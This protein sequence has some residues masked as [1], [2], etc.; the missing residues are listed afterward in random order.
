MG[1]PN[2]SES[3]AHM[4]LEE[5]PGAELRYG[6]ELEK[7]AKL[8]LEGA[9]GQI[10]STVMPEKRRDI[11]PGSQNRE[12]LTTNVYG[13]KMNE[14]VVVYRYEI[15]M[16]AFV[17]KR[18]GSEASIDMHKKQHKDAFII[19]HRDRCREIFNGFLLV[20][21][22][23][24]SA[25]RCVYYDLDSILFSLDDVKL[26]GKATFTV[27][28]EHL[29]QECAHFARCEVEVSPVK[30]SAAMRLGDLS[31]LSLELSEVYRTLTQFLDIA[32][33]QSAMF[34][35]QNHVT[36]NAGLSF[37]LDPRV[38]GFRDEDGA[39]F[40][41]DAAYLSI[42][43]DKAVRYIEGPG[44]RDA[45]CSASII[46]Q[47][48]KTPFHEVGSLLTKAKALMPRLNNIR[49]DDRIK[50]E[51]I[52]KGLVVETTHG[53][54]TQKFVIH[55]I[56]RE[57]AR[58]K[59]IMVN[60][61]TI[62][63]EKYFQEK[64]NQTLTEPNVPL[65]ESRRS[66]TTISYFPM[67]LCNVADNQRVKTQQLSPKMTEL[68]IRKC[69]VPP[70]ILKEQN[71]KVANA[72]NLWNSKYLIEADISVAKRP[73]ELDG[74][75]IAP[76]KILFGN[77]VS[78]EVRP[79]NFTWQ[80]QK[81][82][83]PATFEKWRA[84]AFLEPRDRNKLPMRDF[85]EFLKRFV[86]ECRV[87]GIQIQPLAEQPQ[88]LGSST[89]EIN[90]AFDTAYKDNVFFVLAIHIDGAPGDIPHADVKYAERQH[91]IV[92]QCVELKT[93]LNVVQKNQRVTMQNIVNKT[94]I[95]YGG[96]NYTLAPD[97]ARVKEVLQDNTLY[98][99]FGNNHPG[100]GLG[101]STPTSSV[102]ADGGKN[103]SPKD[104]TKEYVQKIRAKQEEEEDESRP[105]TVVGYS[106]NIGPNGPFDFVGDFYFQE[107]RRQETISVVSEIVTNCAQMFQKRRGRLPERIIIFRGGCSEGQF[108]IILK[109]E[110]PLMKIGLESTGCNA[111]ISVVAV[112]KL[113]N[114]RLFRQNINGNAK[115]PEQNIQPG[116]V[117]NHTVTHPLFAEFFLNSH[118]ALQG[119]AR[120]PKYTVVYDDNKLKMSQF[121]E[122]T[123]L[124]CFSHQIVFLPTSVPSPVY[125]ANCYAD[126]GRVL[127]QRWMAQGGEHH[128]YSQLTDALRFASN[129]VFPDDLYGFRVNA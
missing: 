127:Y 121:E 97:S 96:L 94:N 73:T 15:K 11:E 54:K 125:I 6:T 37:F 86:E 93:M 25:S 29:T 3:L 10:G 27:A 32:T 34:D 19:E 50:L 98:I 101:L 75:V 30:S 88:I 83:V 20:P 62:S 16:K 76:P 110:V 69:A 91:G 104:T 122:M 63:V 111:P 22:I 129:Q 109:Y 70:A 71:T 53:T 14:N 99:G 66:D 23:P 103:D 46:V 115:P 84:I 80:G 65:I 49:E 1:D 26:A 72:L 112:N 79:N 107:P 58:N 128:N 113:Q 77:N 87:K 68:S 44:T 126:R 35:Q 17:A 38:F 85:Q 78:T 108:Q 2:I 106:A 64:Y 31:G 81:F 74:R 40:D 5:N 48:K 9:G 92:S 105:P 21:G 55:A 18:D 118:R 117:V 13:L 123:Y 33:G 39:I 24:F 120:T 82:A 102:H 47:T 95:K 28:T 12:K 45:P 8:V 36:F 51:K 52:L 100:G 116:T 59:Q 114:V 56:C 4:G 57:S 7:K 43:C 61:Q 60:N 124:L 119:T 90:H 89:T 42:G 41:S 67:E